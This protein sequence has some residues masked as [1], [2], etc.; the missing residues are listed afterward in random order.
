MKRGRGMNIDQKI[1]TLNNIISLF[2][3][4]GD[5]KYDNIIS[6]LKDEI[7]LL[8]KYSDVV[9]MLDQ[10]MTLL[11]QA[12]NQKLAIE[13]AKLVLPVDDIAAVKYVK[14]IFG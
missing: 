11:K 5:S 6:N 3:S 9:P 2:V 13:I 12:N 10:V 1:A 14:R 7:A 8:Q 4:M